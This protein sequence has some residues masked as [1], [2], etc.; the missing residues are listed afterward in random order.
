MADALAAGTGGELQCSLLASEGLIDL[1]CLGN[2]VAAIEALLQFELPVIA[3][4]SVH[5]PAVSAHWLA[6]SHWL[7]RVPEAEEQK[8]STELRRALRDATAATESAAVD[9]L[10]AAVTSVSDAFVGIRL[11]GSGAADLLSQ[12]CPLDLA[13]LV[14]GCCARTLLARAQVLLIP[15]TQLA[16]YDLF[17]E[18]S[19]ADYLQEW[20]AAAAGDV[21]G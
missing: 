7:L 15:M 21:V 13:Q 19:Y 20:I 2:A 11:Q 14:P 4:R 12:G 9:S 8:L 16:G 10:S 6:P 18:R 3:N 17:V 5:G 1:Q